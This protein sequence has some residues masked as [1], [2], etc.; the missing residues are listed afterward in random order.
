MLASDYATEKQLTYKIKKG[1]KTHETK[2]KIPYCACYY[3]IFAT[4]NS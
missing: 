2:S 3:G 4:Q 1:D